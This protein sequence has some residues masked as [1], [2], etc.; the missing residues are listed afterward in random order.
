MRDALN[1]YLK[2]IEDWEEIFEYG[3]KVVKKM[4]ITS[5]K[6]IDDIVYEFRHGRKPD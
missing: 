5:K 3:R 1:I 6:Q 2:R 4:G